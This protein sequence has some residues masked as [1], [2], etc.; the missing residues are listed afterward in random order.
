MNYPNEGFAPETIEALKK[1]L[2]ASKKIFKIVPGEE[3]NDEF[4]NFYFIGVFEGK[5]V[6]YDAALYTLR[7]HHS[8]EIYE[9]A[10]HEAAKKFPNFKGIHYEEDENG[11]LKP[12]SSEDEEIGWFITEIIMELEEEETVKVQEFIDLDTNHDFG[13][14]LDAAL[15]VEYIDEEVISK[16]V[17]EFNDDTIEL[18]DTLYAFQSEEEDVD[19]ED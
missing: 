14:G 16:F 1:E 12:L 10:E 8:S 5:E 7:L 18:D 19:D 3:N 9:L 4:V 13:I 11:N 2:K 15:N 17:K 6:I